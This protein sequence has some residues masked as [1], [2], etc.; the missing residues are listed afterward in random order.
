WFTFRRGGL[1]GVFGCG[2]RG[3]RGLVVGPARGCGEAQAHCQHPPIV[4]LL[5]GGS[6]DLISL[7]V[8]VRH[9][10]FGSSPSLIRPIWVRCNRDTVY[11]SASNMRRISR[12]FPSINSISITLRVLFAETSRAREAFS[13]SP[14]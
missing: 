13:C 14:S 10:P 11:P 2:G 9:L 3:C 8:N 5:I 7:S 4:C 12:F 1:C 6:R